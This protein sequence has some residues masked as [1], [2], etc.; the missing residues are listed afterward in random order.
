VRF[1]VTKK[2]RPVLGVVPTPAVTGSDAIVDPRVEHQSDED[3]D[4]FLQEKAAAEAVTGS[5]VIQDGPQAPPRELDDDEVD[6]AAVDSVTIDLPT[7]IEIKPELGEVKSY[8]TPPSTYAHGG[9]VPPH[10]D[11]AE[12]FSPVARHQAVSVRASFDDAT[13]DRLVGVSQANA[14]LEARARGLI[15]ADVNERLLVDLSEAEVN[16]RARSCTGLLGDREALAEEA[17]NVAARYKN[18]LKRIDAELGALRE[19][20]ATKTE[21]QKVECVQVFDPKRER[22]WF[23]Y[24][25]KVLNERRMSD[26]E[27]RETQRSLFR[28][29]P[30]LPNR[31][32]MQATGRARTT[33]ELAKDAAERLNAQCE[34]KRPPDTCVAILSPPEQMP[35]EIPVETPDDWTSVGKTPAEVIAEL[36]RFNPTLTFSQN[37]K[38]HYVPTLR[39]PPKPK[40]Q[41]RKKGD[42]SV[43]VERAVGT[44]AGDGSSS[45][46]IRDVM[47]S[48]SSARGKHDHVV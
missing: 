16:E 48:E 25:G 43:V 10:A 9:V 6:L 42:T 24:R 36:E 13:L 7:G 5:D 4:R 39:A 46:D 33:E 17:K 41:R 31:I 44:D 19:A 12:A 15:T 11:G 8:P 23:L 47:R 14:T 21:H 2:K 38:G 27:C 34:A 35:D 18:D 45:S 29:A 28:D 20:V 37:E 3:R 22:T 30:N 1:I 26:D 32:D 40:R